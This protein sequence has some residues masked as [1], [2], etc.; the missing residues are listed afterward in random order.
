M[1]EERKNA[2]KTADADTK[3][4][5]AALK[6]KKA[7]E[8]KKQKAAMVF[9]IYQMVEAKWKSSERKFYRGFVMTDDKSHSSY[10]IYFPEDSK[11]RKTVPFKDIR[12]MPEGSTGIWS[13]NLNEYKDMVFQREGGDY[14]ILGFGL[15]DKEFECVDLKSPLKSRITF[16]IGLIVR[17]IKRAEEETRKT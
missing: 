10:T 2:K 5:A 4:T 14:Q 6:K 3:K 8:L 9:G 1:A 16:D 17:H 11:T 13:R 15:E 7:A 12:E